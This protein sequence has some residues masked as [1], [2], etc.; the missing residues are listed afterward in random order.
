ML[1]K[2]ERKW[3]ESRERRLEKHGAY[4]CHHCFY[5]CNWKQIAEADEKCDTNVFCFLKDECEDYKDVAKCEALRAGFY[6]QLL[7]Y[8]CFINGNYNTFVKECAAFVDKKM[9]LPLKRGEKY[10]GHESAINAL[11]CTMKN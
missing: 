10:K 11:L 8:L 5:T 9:K 2:R 3:L 7:K 1:N 6:E 4:Y